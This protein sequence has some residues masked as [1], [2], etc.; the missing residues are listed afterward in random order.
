MGSVFTFRSRNGNGQAPFDPGVAFQL[1]PVGLAVLDRDLRFVMCNDALAKINSLPVDQHVGARLADLLPDIHAAAGDK[2]K[3]IFETGEPIDD[4][5]LHCP[6]LTSLDQDRF[7]LESVRA[8]PDESG[9][10][11]HIL[12]SVKEVTALQRAKQ[13]LEEREEQF[14]LSQQMSP[15]GFVIFR[16]MRENSEIVDFEFEYANEAAVRDAKSGE[17]VGLRLLK[18]FPE[19]GA[20]PSLFPR[21]VEL[22]KQQKADVIELQYSDHLLDGWFRNSAVPIGHDRIAVSF[23]DITDKVKLDEEL[24]TIGTEYRHRLKNAYS[25]MAALVSQSAREASC[26]EDLAKDIQGRLIAMATAQDVLAS[27]DGGSLTRLI[28]EVLAPYGGPALHI[29]PG[30]EASLPHEGVVALALALNELATNA[31]KYGALSN[32]KGVVHLGWRRDGE[33]VVISWAETGGPQITTPTRRG[34][35]SRLIERVSRS[36]PGGGVELDFQPQGLRAKITFC[37]T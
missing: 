5:E 4:F 29:E 33:C 25:V 10:I 27:H 34:F 6:A 32:T 23:R 8:L 20:Y 16:A 13:A 19:N 21:F 11:Q 14:R 3:S 30:P 17:L 28:V 9:F 37:D 7:W 12:V 35:G 24:R 18:S 15:D 26:V 31:S 22:I 36:L 2:L 1:A